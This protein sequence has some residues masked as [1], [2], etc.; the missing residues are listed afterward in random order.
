[1]ARSQA[2]QRSAPQR[3]G[4]QHACEMNCAKTPKPGLPNII[5]PLDR[6]S[7]AQQSGEQAPKQPLTIAETVAGLCPRR[8]YCFPSLEIKSLAVGDLPLA[9]ARIMPG[10]N[11]PWRAP[12]PHDPGARPV[13]R[14][15]ELNKD[16][17]AIPHACAPP[18]HMIAHQKAFTVSA[19]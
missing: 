11:A 3:R 16:Y 1:M 4:S 8:Q 14:F 10:A 19:S 7:M 17:D 12:S 13:T 6:P 18:E 2:S 5:A 15:P 9:T